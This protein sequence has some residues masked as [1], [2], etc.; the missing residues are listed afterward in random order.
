MT[1]DG[2]DSRWTTEVVD[3]L[4]N[5]LP[6]AFDRDGWEHMF[7]SAYQMGCEALA[8]LGQAEETEWGAVPLETPRLP[9]VLPRWDDISVAVL[10]LAEQQYKLAY[11]L[12]DGS[13]L[14]RQ[15]A[16]GWTIAGPVRSPPPPNIAAIDGLGPAHAAPDVLSALQA[17]GL[18]AEG[19]W[20]TPAETVLWRIRPRAWGLDFTSDPRFTGAVEQ[21]VSTMPN[22]VRAEMD[23]IVTISEI[24]VSEAVVRGAAANT[25]KRA[26][27]GPNAVFSDPETPEQARLS[28]EF[29]RRN[30]LNWL[31]FRRW[32]LPDGWLTPKEAERA[33][34]IFH[35]L[36]AIEMRRAVA[37]RLY[38]DLPFL[39]EFPP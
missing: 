24:E 1:A 8:A 27:H 18:I 36:L 19:R 2:L 29:W 39:A 11:R 15:A 9:S 32:R 26:K 23:R 20:T 7:S 12:P 37:A 35:D 22:D 21:A 14:P 34:E 17:L 38:T 3:F 6:D 10:G 30:D 4:S 13:V 31:F 5:N 16:P 28:L 33:L 25:E